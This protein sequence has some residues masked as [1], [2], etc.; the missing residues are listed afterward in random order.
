[1]TTASE[2]RRVFVEGPDVDALREFMLALWRER[3]DE[4]DLPA[5][6][7]LSSSCKFGALLVRELHGG[8]IRGNWA[9]VHCRLP[10]GRILDTS[11]WAEDVE[12]IRAR[13]LDPYDHDRAFVRSR[14][15]R[16][17]LETCMP[18]VM[19]WAREWR[20]AQ[21]VLGRKAA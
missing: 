19:E 6:K 17:S 8:E 9:H 10:D 20:M 12:T 21:K 15:F 14:D 2:A 13:S 18:R 4:M 1:V 7:D 16:E 3:A 11:R 5:P